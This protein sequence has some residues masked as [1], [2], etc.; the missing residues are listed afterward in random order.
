MNIVNGKSLE[1]ARLEE[2]KCSRSNIREGKSSVKGRGRVQRRGR[3][4]QDD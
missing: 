3:D 2:R 1:L 4:D